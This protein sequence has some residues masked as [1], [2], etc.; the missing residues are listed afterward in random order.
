MLLKR[1]IYATFYRDEI[2]VLDEACDEMTRLR[3]E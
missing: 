3:S 1:S 2:D